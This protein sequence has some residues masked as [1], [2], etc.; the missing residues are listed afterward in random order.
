M[1]IASTRSGCCEKLDRNKQL[2]YS[3][4]TCISRI[5]VA[6]NERSGSGIVEICRLFNENAVDYIE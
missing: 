2:L 3:N 4:A 1:P 6:V 5:S